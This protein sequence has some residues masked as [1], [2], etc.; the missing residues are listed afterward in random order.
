M[1]NRSEFTANSLMAQTAPN[2]PTVATERAR[3]LAVLGKP[4]VRAPARVG[5]VKTR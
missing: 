4:V 2:V 5:T 3:W 1:S